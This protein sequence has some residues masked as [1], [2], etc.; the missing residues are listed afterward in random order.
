MEVVVT[1]G[2]IRRAKLQSNRHD[3]KPTPSFL[4]AGC[5]SCHPTN[6]FRVLK[7]KQINTL[8]C[9]IY[10]IYLLCIR[11][12]STITVINQLSQIKNLKTYLVKYKNAKKK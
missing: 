6:S 2:A 8:Y 4:Q 3:N 9:H 7:E 1:T 5:P 12:R 11:T 10:F